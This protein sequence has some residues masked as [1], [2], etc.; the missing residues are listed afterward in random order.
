MH[1]RI[2]KEDPECM[3]PIPCK[4][5]PQ[6]KPRIGKSCRYAHV[7]PETVN[8]YKVR[9][10]LKKYVYPHLLL[11]P[12]R[13]VNNVVAITYSLFNEIF[14]TE[15]VYPPRLLAYANDANEALKEYAKILESNMLGLR[16]L[17]MRCVPLDTATG[18]TADEGHIVLNSFAFP[19]SVVRDYT[20]IL[21]QFSSNQ[22]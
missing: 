19:P 22:D 6:C 18:Y 11:K 13:D 14:G 2:V 15:H 9:Q 4:Y 5:Y 16:V 21:P 17:C 1:K 20:E 7:S 10:Y 8:E 12:L 3:I